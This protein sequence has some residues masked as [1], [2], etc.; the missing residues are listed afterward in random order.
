MQQ[1]IVPM[2]DYVLERVV[3]DGRSRT[4]A[5]TILSVVV[6]GYRAQHQ[7]IEKANDLDDSLDCSVFLL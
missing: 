7:E 6:G 4:S 5:P 3:A 2:H 1:T